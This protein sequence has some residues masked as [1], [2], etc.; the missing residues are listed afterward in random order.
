MHCAN[1]TIETVKTLSRA[2]NETQ[3]ESKEAGDES[4]R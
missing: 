3:V 4:Y 1:L 2:E